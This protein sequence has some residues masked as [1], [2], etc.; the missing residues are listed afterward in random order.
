[1]VFVLKYTKTCDF[2]FLNKSIV[3]AGA[4]LLAAKS[5]DEPVLLHRLAE[6]V[7]LLEKARNGG[8]SK[9]PTGVKVNPWLW[10][11]YEQRISSE[12]LSILCNIGFDC[13]LDLPN[14]HIAKFARKSFGGSGEK[15]EKFAFQFLND[16]FQTNCFLIFHPKVIAAA[17]ILMSHIFMRQKGFPVAELQQNWQHL[18]DEHITLESVI[19]AKNEIK[20]VYSKEGL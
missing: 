20:R 18:I 14:S 2:R 7:I 12:E 19:E 10:E 6:S 4:F 15:I 17:C 1:M 16:S 5:R 9:V 11:E 3:S 8:V 13:D